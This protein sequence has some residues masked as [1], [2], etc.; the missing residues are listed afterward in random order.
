MCSARESINSMNPGRSLDSRLCSPGGMK[1]GLRLNC[2]GQQRLSPASETVLW[3]SARW[4]ISSSTCIETP[5]KFAGSEREF[6]SCLRSVRFWTTFLPNSYPAAGVSAV[7]VTRK[8]ASTTHMR[9]PL[10]ATTAPAVIAGYA[11]HI[12]LT[13]KTFVTCGVEW[14][15]LSGYALLF[16]RQGNAGP[17]VRSCSLS[18]L[19]SNLAIL[20]SCNK[21]VTSSCM[22]QSVSLRCSSH[23][24]K[25][26]TSG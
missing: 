12:P 18:L 15:R 3:T 24:A 8:Q 26:C 23:S 11:Y 17:S 21:R 7:F 10:S 14:L 5:F 13:Y 1:A 25:T 22:T 16:D 2:N 4:G 20:A 6:A 19:Q 9:T